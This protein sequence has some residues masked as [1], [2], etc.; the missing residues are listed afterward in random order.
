M[1][2]LSAYRKAARRDRLEW[3]ETRGEPAGNPTFC[4]FAQ[5]KAEKL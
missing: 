3:A 2:T 1:T 4:P 5:S